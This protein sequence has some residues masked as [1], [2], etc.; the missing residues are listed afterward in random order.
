MGNKIPEYLVPF[1]EYEFDSA[2]KHKM[3]KIPEDMFDEKTDVRCFYRSDLT[4]PTYYE[5]RELPI[6]SDS[7]LKDI[8]DR[9]L[10]AWLC[11]YCQK[12]YLF[13]H[14]MYK[15]ANGLMPPYSRNLNGLWDIC[16]ICVIPDETALKLLQNR[17]NLETDE[18]NNRQ[19][20]EESFAHQLRVKY[21]V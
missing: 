17:E 9:K 14:N 4:I 19:K 7:I 21:G 8:S 13:P 2:V 6:N 3:N 20:K 18:R 15:K 11:T 5:Q 10:G 16:F 12:P 1:D